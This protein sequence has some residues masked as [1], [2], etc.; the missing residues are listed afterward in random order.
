MYMCDTHCECPIVI[1]NIQCRKRKTDSEF[2][3]LRPLYTFFVCYT[4]FTFVLRFRF[5]SVFTHSLFQFVINSYK[6]THLYT[7]TTCTYMNARLSQCCLRTLDYLLSC[8]RST[9]LVT[10]DT[11]KHT[12]SRLNC[13]ALRSALHSLQFY[14]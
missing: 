12:R 3:C 14:T 5:C 13:Q 8:D 1:L 11:H 10:T 4:S 9:V 6:H 7:P 2:V